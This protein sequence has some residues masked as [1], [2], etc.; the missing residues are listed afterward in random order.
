MELAYH[1]DCLPAA[2]RAPVQGSL[3]AAAGHT[4][5]PGPASNDKTTMENVPWHTNLVFSGFPAVSG[6]APRP[7]RFTSRML[8]ARESSPL[9]IR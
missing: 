2:C 5:V 4:L 8:S 9:N 7:A 3:L 1:E 6:L